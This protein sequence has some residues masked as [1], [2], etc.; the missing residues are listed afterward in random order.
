M[1]FYYYSLLN[2]WPNIYRTLYHWWRPL[3]QKRT[4]ICTIIL[5]GDNDHTVIAHLKKRLHSVR[6]PHCTFRTCN[7][8]PAL[9]INRLSIMR[10]WIR[11]DCKDHKCQELILIMYFFNSIWLVNQIFSAF[12]FFVSIALH[13]GRKEQGWLNLTTVH[14]LRSVI[15]PFTMA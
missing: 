9:G 13:G 2:W 3:S 1:F 15:T 11:N 12:S 10:N 7:F 14:I 8:V 5:F 4:I 6:V